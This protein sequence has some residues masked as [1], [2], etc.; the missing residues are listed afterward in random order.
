[1]SHG[2]LSPEEFGWR[3]D[4]TEEFRLNRS[5]LLDGTYS[6]YNKRLLPAIQKQLKKMKYN[7]TD[8]QQTKSQ[9]QFD[10]CLGR[11]TIMDYSILTQE[12]KNWDRD[13]FDMGLYELCE[14]PLHKRDGKIASFMRNKE[15]MQKLRERSPNVYRRLRLESAKMPLENTSPEH[16]KSDWIHVALRSPINGKML[17]LSEYLT[18]ANRDFVTDPVDQMTGRSIISILHQ[19]PF[20]I[21]TMLDDMAKIFKKIIEWNGKNLKDLKDQV[22]LFRYEHAHAMPFKRGSSA[23]AEWFEGA[24]YGMHGMKVAYNPEKLV[25]LEALTLSLKEF[26][27]NY[28]T[29]ITLPKIKKN[30]S[31]TR[32]EL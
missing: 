7:L 25:D 19:D 29:M 27:D 22:A 5:N 23:V 18:W 21:E 28:D 2:T 12:Y 16:A 6:E 1:V 26:V 24:L 14:V 8:F 30:S 13:P 31:A 10:R 3:R 32:V 9:V 4:G 17:V 11:R 20:L 15:A